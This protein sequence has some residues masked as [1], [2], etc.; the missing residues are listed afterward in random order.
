[1]GFQNFDPWQA[2]RQAT[3]ANPNHTSRKTIMNT[4]KLIAALALSFAASGAA[5][6]QE[7]TYEYPQASTSTVTRAQV[8]A[9]LQQARADGTLHITEGQ[10]HK[11]ASFVA[12][13]SRA[14]VRAEAKAAAASGESRLLNG[15]TNAFEVAIQPAAGKPTPTL[16]A[17]SVSGR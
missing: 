11:P 17:K 1:L 2:Q 4:T 9:E 6:A 16:V 15:E 5:L 13:R 7:A 12:Q 8:L 10:T 3:T 14:E